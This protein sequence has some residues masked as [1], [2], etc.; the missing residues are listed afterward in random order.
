MK[1]NPEITAN[2]GRIIVKLMIIGSVLLGFAYA[3]LVVLNSVLQA[4]H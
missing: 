2:P 3:S 4:I 1:R